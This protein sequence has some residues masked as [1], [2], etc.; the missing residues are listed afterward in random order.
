MLDR[1][2]CWIDPLINFLENSKLSLDR[3]EA[4]KIKYKS[5]KYLLHQRKLYNRSF[6]L[7]LLW[8]LHPIET[9]YAPRKVHEGIC[10]N[11]IGKKMLAYM[12]L[13]LSY[14]WPAMQQNAEDFD[15]QCDASQRNKNIQQLS[16]IPITPICAP[17]PSAQWGMDILNL[18][19]LVSG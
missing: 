6:S 12:L 15:M 5:S 18:F 2:P 4:R 17:W 14:Y 8:C 10:D 16:A 9:K 11:H 1:E 13:Q 3:K 7:P 19:P